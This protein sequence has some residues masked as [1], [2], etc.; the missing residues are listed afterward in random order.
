MLV[1]V[2]DFM[3]KFTKPVLIK[4]WYLSSVNAVTQVM[5]V[6]VNLDLFNKTTGGL[7]V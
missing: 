2:F 3:T 7:Q 6:F 1:M 5:T 4:D